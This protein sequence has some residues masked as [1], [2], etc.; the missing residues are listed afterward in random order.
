MKRGWWSNWPSLKVVDLRSNSLKEIHSVLDF[1][2]PFAHNLQSL[3]LDHN[4]IASTNTDTHV[5]PFPRLTSLTL[6][7]NHI[8]H[9]VGAPGQEWPSLRSLDLSH[10]ALTVIPMAMLSRARSLE[11]LRLAGNPL[12]DPTFNVR[13]LLASLPHLRSLNLDDCGIDR[14]SQQTLGVV[15]KVAGYGVQMSFLFIYS[16]TLR[17]SNCRCATTL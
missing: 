16:F 13:P 14:I 10:N 11:D 9:V 8:Q 4:A 2:R 15:I 1:L 5:F 12:A 7:F 17:W 3:H 6:S